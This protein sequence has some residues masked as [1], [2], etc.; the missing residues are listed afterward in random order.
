MSGKPKSCFASEANAT[1]P[2]HSVQYRGFSPN[3]S[4]LKRS[5]SRS[6]SYSAIAHIPFS[7]EKRPSRHASQPFSR[8]SQSPVDV[9]VQPSATSSSRSFHVV[10]DLAIEDDAARPSATIGWLPVGARSRMDR[11]TKPRTASRPGGA[12][13]SATRARE[14]APPSP[15]TMRRR[16]QA[17]GV[18]R[19]RSPPRTTARPAARVRRS[20]RCRRWLNPLC[21]FEPRRVARCAIGDTVPRAVHRRRTSW[22]PPTVGVP[23]ALRPFGQPEY[24]LDPVEVAQ[25]PPLVMNWPPPWIAPGD[26]AI[27]RRRSS[28]R[29]S[30]TRHEWSFI[31][32][33]RARSRC[34]PRRSRH[35]SP[36]ACP[37]RDPSSN[38]PRLPGGNGLGGRFG[39]RD[40]V[41][42]SKEL[43]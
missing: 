17:R 3:L 34:V 38:A 40:P 13:P 12:V 25:R 39:R 8:T 10:V 27:A 28:P 16:R 32:G 29:I 5:A 19:P 42:R 30:M 31:V 18:G 6:A 14:V 7:R 26:G 15:A 22:V 35:R 24:T 37:P 21:T 33:R 1:P 20:R 43:R 36:G 23:C 41:D 11:R 9:N 4:R 2:R